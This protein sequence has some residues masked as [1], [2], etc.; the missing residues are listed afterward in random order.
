[1]KINE[2]SFYMQIGFRKKQNNRWSVENLRQIE[3][4]TYRLVI[5]KVPKAV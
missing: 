5:V 3:K 2:L 4:S 1:M